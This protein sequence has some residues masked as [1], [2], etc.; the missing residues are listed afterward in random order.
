[1]LTITNFITNYQTI[2]KFTIE[3]NFEK[4]HFDF[5][6]PFLNYC[7]TGQVMG[8]P[9]SLLHST[10][11]V[12]IILDL[13]TFSNSQWVPVK[14]FD[15]K[16]KSHKSLLFA[17]EQLNFTTAPKDNLKWLKGIW[18]GILFQNSNVCR[19]LESQT[20]NFFSTILT[21]G[22]DTKKCLLYVV[23]REIKTSSS[24][25]VRYSRFSAKQS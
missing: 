15:M 1:M 17:K 6:S 18:K 5:W 10:V 21:I 9:T 4:L 14:P 19:I 8:L 25:K 13:E 3:S 22:F 23:L 7:S 2:C 24:H 20:S 16:Q 12:P 11:C